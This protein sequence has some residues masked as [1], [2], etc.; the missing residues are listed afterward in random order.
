M[1]IKAALLIATLLFVLTAN[2]EGKRRKG[3]LIG[4]AKDDE[5]IHITIAHPS[6]NAA[7]LDTFLTNVYDPEHP[8]YQQFPFERYVP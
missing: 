4:P 3:K 8:S 2:L 6:P 1:R 7:E 5:I